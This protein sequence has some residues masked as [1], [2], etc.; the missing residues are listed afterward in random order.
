MQSLL[1]NGF[2]VNW[3]VMFF[4]KRFN[5]LESRFQIFIQ[6]FGEEARFFDLTDFF[7]RFLKP[8]LNLFFRVGIT[9]S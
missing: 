1:T 4:N 5:V 9:S 8:F 7:K 3:V 2:K 6:N